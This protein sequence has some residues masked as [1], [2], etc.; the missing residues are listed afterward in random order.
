MFPPRENIR[1]ERQNN[2]K[3]I[4]ILVVVL[5]SYLDPQKDI[6]VFL[7]S[8]NPKLTITSIPRDQ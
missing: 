5:V 2:K 8:F 1:G 7:L 4:K 3:D 6:I